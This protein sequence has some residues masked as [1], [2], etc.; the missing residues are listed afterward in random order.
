MTSADVRVHQ[1]LVDRRVERLARLAELLE[2]EL[3]H[4]RLERLGDRLEPAVELAVLAGP[5]D[6]VEHREQLGER[7]RDG[8]LATSS[9]SRSTR[10]R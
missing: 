6:V 10:L 2:A 4:G 1:R 9:R 5:A 3:R 7:G 8:L